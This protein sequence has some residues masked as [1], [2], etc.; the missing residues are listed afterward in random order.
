MFYPALRH[1]YTHIAAIAEVG[2]YFYLLSFLTK[3]SANNI[4]NEN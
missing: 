2:L 1:W 3:T 4:Y